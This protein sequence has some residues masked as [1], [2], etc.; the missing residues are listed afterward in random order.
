[1]SDEFFFDATQVAPATG[2]GDPVPVGKYPLAVEVAEKKTNE[3]G[4]GVDCTIAIL[5][6]EYKNRKLFVFFN[7][8]HENA[9]AQRIGQEQFSALCHA[10]ETLQPRALSELLQKPFMGEVGIRKRKDTGEPQ[11][12][13]NRYNKIDGSKITGTTVKQFPTAAR[14]AATAVPGW[15]KKVG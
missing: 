8:Q 4:W 11:N 3:K 6:G 14:P 5:D 10:V 12:V 15:A 9:D 7:M 2:V 13:I 1:M